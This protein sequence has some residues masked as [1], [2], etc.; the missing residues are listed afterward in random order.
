MKVMRK[1]IQ[2]DEELC[3]GCGMCVP[4][5]AEGSLEIVDGK[6]RVIAE[7]LC[8]GLGAC[9]GEC[10]NGALRIVEREA[11]EFDEEAVEKHLADGKK[12]PEPAPLMAGGCPSARI[13]QFAPASGG[14]RRAAAGDA[15]DGD[16]SELTHWPV[17][18]HLVPPTAPFLKGA[19]LLVL[20]DCVPVAFPSLHRD[21]LKGKAVMMGL[22][23]SATCLM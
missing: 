20:A 18:I 4:S 8:D 17:Q 5:C 2:I 15:A 21:F 9:L 16:A 13:R 22:L 3:D 10:P 23:P 1:I 12:T 7:K 6:V 19:D 11:E 14:T